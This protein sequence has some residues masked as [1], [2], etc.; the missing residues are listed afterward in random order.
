MATSNNK[1]HFAENEWMKQVYKDSWGKPR[2]PTP[3][4]LWII[5]KKR[6]LR[7]WLK[8]VYLFMLTST[9]M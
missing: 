3:R 6:A 8:R 2:R 1:D 9:L 4:K 5:K 7:A